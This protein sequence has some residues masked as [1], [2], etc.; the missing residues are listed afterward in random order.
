MVSKIKKLEG[1]FEVLQYG[2]LS[3]D[4]EKYPLFAIKTHGF[5]TTGK[6]VVL[7]TGGVHGYE[8][9]GVQG[10][11]RFLE[12]RAK[13]YAGDFDILVAPCVSPWGYE[14]INRWNPK[15]VDPNRSFKQESD[16]EEA[17]AVMKLVASVKSPVLMHIDLHESWLSFRK[18]VLRETLAASR[19]SSQDTTDTDESEFC[20]AKAAR[21]G[22]E[23]V[24]DGIPDGFYTV[25]QWKF[26][27]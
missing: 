24:P 11:L 4:T 18:L 5:G 16:S 22:T 19:S 6:P 2:A 27:L 14:T 17:A 10:A 21:D 8:T 9:S 25:T 26:I 15:A 23:Y 12:S 1:D 13:D 7:I 3:Y 20:P